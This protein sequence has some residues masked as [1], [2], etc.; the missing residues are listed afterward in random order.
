MVGGTRSLCRP[1]LEGLLVLVMLLRHWNGA[2]AYTL[3]CLGHER[4]LAIT[5][6][7]DGLVGRSRQPCSPWLGMYGAALGS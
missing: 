7:V 1:G 6:V 2:A 5:T 4:R 3:V